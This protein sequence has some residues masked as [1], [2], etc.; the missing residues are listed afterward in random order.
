MNFETF[1]SPIDVWSGPEYWQNVQKAPAVVFF[2]FNDFYADNIQT[3]KVK[4]LLEEKIP[5][6]QIGILK[7]LDSVAANRFCEQMFLFEAKIVV[8][9]G[10]T[11]N[12]LKKDHTW[13]QIIIRQFLVVLIRGF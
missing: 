7:C 2:D 10:F 12:D 9:K 3:R 13:P 1:L 8:F 4:M 5:N 11:G 6:C